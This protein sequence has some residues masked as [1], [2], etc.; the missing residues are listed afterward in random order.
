MFTIAVV[1]LLASGAS[2]DQIHAEKMEIDS[3]ETSSG[4]TRKSPRH[5]VRNLPGEVTRAVEAAIDAI[6]S[7]QALH[8]GL[9][10]GQTIVG[11][12]TTSDGKVQVQTKDAGSVVIAKD[13][14]VVIRSDKDQAAYDAAL[15][16]LQH[17]HLADFWR[18]DGRHWPQ[19]DDEEIRPPLPTI[20]AGRAVRQTDRDKITVYTTAVYGKNDT[21]A[22]SQV[23]A[24]QITGGIRSEM[25]LISAREA[26]RLRQR[27]FNS[28][29]LQ[30][31][32]LQN[33]I[34]GGVGIHLD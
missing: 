18:R 23:I 8:V 13:A 2:A 5:Q 19:L 28:N 33:V 17:P 27:I 7:T 20:S 1:V 21:T 10:D 16:R 30:N 15:E 11:T 32:N 3:R 26:S 6:V 12:A 22:P 4:R 9:K 34:D 14:I 25:C 31:L 29:A 24:H